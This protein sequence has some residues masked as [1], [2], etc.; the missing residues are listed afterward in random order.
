VLWTPTV[1]LL[2]SF[3][4]ERFRVEGY[5]P[6]QEFGA[7]LALALGR[8]AFMHKQWA[9]AE[10]WYN[11]AVQDY[12]ATRGAAEAVYWAGV[13]YYK[14]SNDHTVLGRVGQELAEKFP[15]SIWAEKASVWLPAAPQAKT[16]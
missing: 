5:L 13:S 12:A 3:G 1:L 4:V 11:H 10:K 15:D 2:D 16:A 14:K 6:R 7:H 9:E 8:I